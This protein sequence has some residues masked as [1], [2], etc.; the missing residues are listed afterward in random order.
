MSEQQNEQIEDLIVGHFDG[1]LTAEQEKE[2]AA[3]LS[4]SPAAKHLFLS[5]MRMEGRLHSLGRDGFIQ[6]P[7]TGVDPLSSRAP[8]ANEVV[9][10]DTDSN[11]SLGSRFR[12]TATSLAI[13]A[14]LIL[15]V[16]L[17]VLSP[18]SVS[19][20]TVLGKARE[21]AAE[22]VDRTY[23]LTLSHADADEGDQ[24]RQLK[25]TLRG[26][27]LFVV[28]PLS[29]RYVMGSDGTDYWLAWNG[30]KSLPV[31]V[32]NDFRTLAPE[33]RRKIPNRR[34]LELAASPEEPLLLSMDSLLELIDNRYDVELIDSENDALHHVRATLRSERSNRPKTVDLWSDIDSG[35]VNRI[36]L[37]F[38]NRRR[39]KFELGETPA[40]SDEWYHY[41]QHAPQREVERLGGN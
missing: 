4:S 11:T 13:C 12:A 38:P 35:V 14:S 23:Q 40:L 41:S 3:A 22:L 34:L 16:S 19:A 28:Q 7:Q 32:T 25:I 20:S 27:G 29:D 9:L 5:H 39:A 31:W 2:L 10:S 18:T 36:E 21:A 6:E 24:T 1:T 37:A 8:E 33:L 17:W 30:A 26:G 15:A